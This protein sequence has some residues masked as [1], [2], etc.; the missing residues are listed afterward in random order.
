MRRGSSHLRLF[1]TCLKRQHLHI[2][3]SWPLSLFCSCHASLLAVH[4]CCNLHAEN[5]GGC[6]LEASMEKE[7][8]EKVGLV[9]ADVSKM[10]SATLDRMGKIF[11]RIFNEF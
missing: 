3:A 4:T 7:P 6:S 5:V 11:D 2:S 8:S 1:G 9:M 10:T